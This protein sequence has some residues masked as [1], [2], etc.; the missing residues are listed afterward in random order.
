M[1]TTDDACA[2][3]EQYS[4]TGQLA[5]AEQLFRY[6][7]ERNPN[8]APALYGLA[9][10]ALQA[11]NWVPAIDWLRRAC[12]ADPGCADCWIDLGVAYSKAGYLVEAVAACEKALLL[13]PYSA[14]AANNLGQLYQ[15]MGETDRAVATYRK[16]LRE[17]PAYADAHV[18]LASALKEQGVLDQA[19]AH[20]REALRLQPDQVHAYYSLSQLAAE[21][22]Y[23]FTPADHEQLRALLVSP[24]LSDL[25]RSVAG[26]ALGT[27]LDAQGAYA[28]AFACFEQA[29]ELRRHWQRFN[30]RTFD[31]DGHAALVN[32]AIATF[33]RAYFQRMRLWETATELPIFIVGMPRSGTTLVEQILAS[34]P[35]VYG[36]GELGEF[37]RIMY[38]L[39]GRNGNALP[40][41]IP[42]ATPEVAHDVSDRYLGWLAELASRKGASRVTDKDFANLL[43]LG[44]LATLFPR[45]RII[46]CR[47]D[48]RDVSLSCYFQNFQYMDFSWSLEETAFYYGQHERLMAHWRQVLPIP[49]HEVCYEELIARQEPVTRRLLAYCGLDWDER[50][51]SFFSTRRVVQTA[52]TIQVRKPLSRKA[53]GRWKHYQPHLGPLLAA[54]RANHVHVE[55]NDNRSPCLPAVSSRTERELV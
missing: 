4:Q 23:A 3:A 33:D 1:M 34:H 53:V 15:E 55:N 20:Y 44:L 36:A 46:Y 28:E 38:R 39:A 19:V 43:Y 40:R 48:P 10:L 14:L 41:P 18:G 5:A 9:K 13:R 7:V 17:Q 47:R 30:K 52:S 16:A 6:A 37:A 35:Q 24:S 12:Q 51:L 26:F 29:N 49:I 42:F 11:C 22:K 54:L 45:A 31:A 2:L 27:V 21:G 32:E 25:S 50:C 8:H